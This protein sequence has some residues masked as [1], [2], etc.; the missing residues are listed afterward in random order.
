M[1]NNFLEETRKILVQAKEEMKELKHPDVV[2]RCVA[3]LENLGIVFDDSHN[4]DEQYEGII[5]KP[6]SKIKMY[7]IPTNEE[8]KIAEE[9]ATEEEI[10]IDDMN[11]SEDVE[12]DELAEEE[13]EEETAE[14]DEV[15]DTEED[16]Q[17]S[18][19]E[20][21]EQIEE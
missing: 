11:V 21:E 14:A 15:E 7:I 9:E 3:G 6:E 13:A 19:E 20:L 5:S 8:L 4:D 10:V 2:N 17:E 16:T 12:E 1:Y 18:E